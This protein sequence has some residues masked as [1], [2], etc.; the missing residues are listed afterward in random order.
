VLGCLVLCNSMLR[1]L[2][3][4][5][6]ASAPGPRHLASPLALQPM[7]LELQ[8][9]AGSCLMH[10]L[11]FGAMH[12]CNAPHAHKASPEHPLWCFW[13]GVMVPWH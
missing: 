5:T 10:L 6:M 3:P 2:L 13:D 8:A 9:G 4:T 7:V 1:V 12:S 11:L